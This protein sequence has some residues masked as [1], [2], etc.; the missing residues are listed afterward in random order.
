MPLYQ[1]DPAHSG[2]TFKIRHMMIA[3]VKGEFTRINGT[4][5]F[6]P[7]NPG[8]SSI[9]VTIDAASI[10]TRE[11]Q[12]DD[13][14]RSA[15]FFDVA[16]FPSIT[17]KS[18]NVVSDEKDSYE[19]TGDLTIHGVTQPVSLL[20]DAVTPEAKDPWGGFRRGAEATATIN[21]KDFGLTYNQVLEAGG[22]MIGDEIE[23][24]LEVELVKAA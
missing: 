23:I 1:I 3:H 15:D 5:D 19:M 20:V 13:H 16:Q 6:D 21:R 8:A 24:S 7:A 4:V 17:F 2:A 22:V 10:H 18:R 9:N 12:R 14:L 11:Q